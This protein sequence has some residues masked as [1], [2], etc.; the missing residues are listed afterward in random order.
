MSWKKERRFIEEEAQSPHGRFSAG[1]PRVSDGAL[2]FLQHMISKME[3]RGSR[4]AIVF[5][6]SPLF[7][8]DA[9]S[10][11]SEIRRWIIEN[12]W[13]EAIVALPTEMFYNTGIAT[14][15]WIVTNRKP[16]RRR[17]KVQL[18]DASGISTKMRKSLGN[19]RNYLT[20]AQ[21]EEVVALYAAFEEGE[22]V[23]IF[24]NEDFGYTKVRV[25]RPERKKNGEIKRDRSGKPKPDTKLRD[26]ERVPLKEDVDAYFEREVRAARARRLDG[27]E[28]GQ[29]GL[30]DQLHPVL[31]QVREAAL[32]GGDHEGDPGARRGDGGDAAGGAGGMKRYPEY[33][34]SGVEWLGQVP[35]HWSV[36]ATSLSR[37][38]CRVVPAFRRTS[39]GAQD[40][41]IPFSESP[42]MMTEGNS[43]SMA[44]SAN[45]VDADTAARLR[46]KCA[47]RRSRHLPEGGSSSA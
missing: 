18:V 40:G 29:G 38:A 39:T 45:Y 13:L 27:P 14:Y 43:A 37:N 28:R 47:T 12:D 22:R 35:T 24:D 20:D 23:R 36:V 2:L 32:G 17:G 46:A 1:T 21:I 26:Y 31:L 11:E 3:P 7:T 4:I 42:D 5:N 10:G 25:E 41:D 6:G 30:R 33:K 19:K 34:E 44:A 15:L 8:G 16:E 9:G